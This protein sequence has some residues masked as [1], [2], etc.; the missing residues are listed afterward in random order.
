MPAF[1]STREVAELFGTETWRV[2][3]LFEDG[4]LKEPGRFAGKR[5]IPREALPQILDALRSRGW[6]RE[7]EAATA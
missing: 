2:R 6:I 4:T 7:A 1:F 3:R 5:A